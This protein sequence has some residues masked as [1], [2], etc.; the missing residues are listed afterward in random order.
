[1]RA[2]PDQ[3]DYI[4][5][6]GGMDTET[7]PLGIPPGRALDL[8]NF[9][10]DV[11]GGY[12]RM[13]GYER[14]DGRPAPSASTY[15]VLEMNDV[16]GIT[17]GS[18]ITGGTSGATGVVLAI[19]GVR[20][21]ITAK[22]GT[23]VVNEAIVGKP[24]IVVE[25]PTENG[26]ETDEEDAAWG[27]LAENHYRASIAA[28][29][30]D[31]PI[32]GVW[33][34]NNT[35]YAWRDDS[36]VCKVYKST[37]SGWSLVSYPKILKWDGGSGAVA[38]GATIT[39]AT[40]GATA[41]VRRTVQYSG[42]YG[43]ST[44][45]GY[46]VLSGVTGTF[47]NNENIQVS[48]VTKCVADG[49]DYTHSQTEGGRYEF[50]NH[51][52][53]GS[54]T[55]YRIYGCDGVNPAFEFDGTYF[56]P[57]LLPNITG[58][59]ATNTPKYVEA[60]RG[61]LFL[62]F[63]NGSLQ[64]SVQGEPLT[65]DGFLGAQEFGLGSDIT[66]LK[67]LTGGVLA[68]HTR[69]KS[70]GLQGSNSG[71]WVLT[72]IAETSGAADYS[73]QALGQTYF[74]D[75]HGVTT[76]TRVQAFGDFRANSLSG[77]VKSAVELVRDQFVA[78]FIVRKSNQYRLIG[79]DGTGVLFYINPRGQLEAAVFEY[80]AQPVCIYNC[81]DENGDEHIYFGDDAG[82]VY[83]AEVGNNHDGATITFFMR[84]PFNSLRSP[85]LRKSYRDVQIEIETPRGF[86]MKV[87]SELDYG[88]VDNPS[89]DVTDID[90][91]FGAGSWNVSN[92]EEFFW[93]AQTIPS[94][95]IPLTGTGNNISLL[96]YGT[97]ATAKPFV[98]QGVLL[99]YRPRRLHRG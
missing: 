8:V 99:R 56:C 18:T 19:D 7:P 16:S 76:L 2:A 25:L 33:R 70:Y 29:P 12:R 41:T 64:H 45:A 63:A 90:V 21:A 14:F 69:R 74:L 51:N 67:S 85:R 91:G 58:V 54:S 88:S 82:M 78:S 87:S 80:P 42:T 11:S 3:V 52:F 47:Q 65:F 49:A 73:V 53:Y 5:L 50:V 27:L 9:E 75:D 28:V 96:M 59:P 97:S 77:M 71:D 68:V 1:M 39:G 57:I 48:A 37:A 81:D 94:P 4:A 34:L 84:L 83:E 61:H 40:S 66:G 35:V 72:T 24:G 20:I 43:G 92:W 95:L 30:G 89:Q 15:Y 46:F 6:G 23:F 26:A 17:V 36:T 44:A 86:S 79:E 10:P 22:T 60:H 31:G 32:R 13:Y 62:A 93:D 98:V 38:E 55:T